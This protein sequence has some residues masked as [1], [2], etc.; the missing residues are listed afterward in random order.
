VFVSSPSFGRLQQQQ[1]GRAGSTSMSDAQSVTVKS[2]REK[3]KTSQDDFV[4]PAQEAPPQTPWKK[5]D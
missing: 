2:T 3:E 4:P 5:L 1:Q